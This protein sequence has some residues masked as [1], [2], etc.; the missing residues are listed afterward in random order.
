MN[1][2]PHF[3]NSETFH[4]VNAILH[5]EIHCVEDWQRKQT[6]NVLFTVLGT[7]FYLNKLTQKFYCVDS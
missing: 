7:D 2:V 3:L 6:N 5:G 4:L 1:L